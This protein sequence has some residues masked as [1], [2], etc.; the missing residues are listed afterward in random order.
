M[1]E[2]CEIERLETGLKD[3]CLYISF[4][5]YA[6]MHEKYIHFF[7]AT[8]CRPVSLEKLKVFGCIIYVSVYRHTGN[9][10]K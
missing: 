7:L 9:L 4:Q 1:P 2:N 3:S 6:I 8:H 10:F 5:M